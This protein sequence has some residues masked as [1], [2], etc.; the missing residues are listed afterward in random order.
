MS[1]IRR[2]KS[3][4]WREYVPPKR[5]NVIQHDVKSHNTVTLKIVAACY[6]ETLVYGVTIIFNSAGS[7]KTRLLRSGLCRNWN[8]YKTPTALT[9]HS[10]GKAKDLCAIHIN[11]VTKSAPSLQNG[12]ASQI[13]FYPAN[14][15][16]CKSVAK[17]QLWK[18]ATVQQ[19]LLGNSS[20]VPSVVLEARV[21]AGSNTST[22]TLRVVGGDEKGS[23]KSERVKYGRMTALARTSSIYKRQT[24]LLVREGTPQEQNRNCQRVTNIW[25]WALDGARHQDLLTD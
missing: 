24:R 12:T 3:W 25:S 14:I 1:H 17:Q 11:Q 23:L 5:W 9:S 13:N 7:G 6:S 2:E 16:T 10:G 18:H 19:P 4:K 22:V 8:F 15:V 21:E 20:V